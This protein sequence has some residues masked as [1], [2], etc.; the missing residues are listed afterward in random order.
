MPQ[1]TLDIVLNIP[2]IGKATGTATPRLNI[3]APQAFMMAPENISIG[4]II[5]LLPKIRTLV[6]AVTDVVAKVQL[7]IAQAK[8][9]DYAAAFATLQIVV[10]AIIALWPQIKDVID[11][12]K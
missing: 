7:M 9:G 6:P 11:S 5:G 4:G 2:F 8:A 1:G 3:E 12:L 10:P